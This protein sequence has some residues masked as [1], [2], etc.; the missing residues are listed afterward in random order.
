MLLLGSSTYIKKSSP[1]ERGR[2]FNGE[3]QNR[4]DDT[5]IFSPL[6]Y[7]LSYLALIR[8]PCA[9]RRWSSGKLRSHY[10]TDSDLRGKRIVR[11]DGE[12]LRDFLEVTGF[13]KLNDVT[14]RGV[15]K[16]KHDRLKKASKRTVNLE[17]T[18]AK[19]M[20]NKLVELG[21]I[22]ENPIKAVKK[23]RDPESICHGGTMFFGIISPFRSRPPPPAAMCK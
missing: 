6:L 17:V 10:Y 22:P 12:T 8:F 18:M 16:F 20:F 14:P 3:G 4:T 1:R 5:R 23:I 19:A 21:V 2:F 7:Q 9:N 15:E 13:K 11:R